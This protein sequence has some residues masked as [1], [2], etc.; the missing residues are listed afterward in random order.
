MDTDKA[1][2]ILGEMIRRNPLR[3]QQ[4]ACA[5]AARRAIAALG[6]A[7]AIR[8]ACIGLASGLFGEAYADAPDSEQDRMI[9]MM[10]QEYRKCLSLGQ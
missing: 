3:S 6:P 1:N 7:D 9:S 8:D 10:E 5:V 2:C 4:E